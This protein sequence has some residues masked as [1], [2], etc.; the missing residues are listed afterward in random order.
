[1]KLKNSQRHYAELSYREIHPDLSGN[2]KSSVVH[3]R[4]YVKYA[5]Y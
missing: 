5:S 4:Y 3:L 2:V 1:M